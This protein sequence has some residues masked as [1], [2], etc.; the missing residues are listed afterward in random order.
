MSRSG[1]PLGNMPSPSTNDAMAMKSTRRDSPVLAQDKTESGR[2]GLNSP[3]YP[4]HFQG[5]ANTKG[6]TPGN[7]LFVSSSLNRICLV[8]YT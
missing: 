7:S 1:Y 2:S 4:I 3:I 6:A 5:P 8:Q